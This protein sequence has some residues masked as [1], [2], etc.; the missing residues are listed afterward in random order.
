[1]KSIFFPY[2]L[3]PSLTL[4]NRIVMAPMT[5]RKAGVDYSPTEQRI[6]YYARRS[7]AG[8][9]ITEGTLISADAI[10]YGNV[11]GIFRESHIEGWKRVTD[12]VHQN[13]GCIF[14][15]LW[16]CGRI[17]HHSFHEGRA[18]IS[19][20][21]TLANVKLGSTN[22]LCSQAKEATRLDITNLISDF[23]Y[24]AHNAIRAGF[25]GVEIHAANGY[26]LDQFLHYSTNHRKDE[27]G[28]TPE[29]I[30][31]FPLEVVHAC[32]Q[33][34]GYEKVGIRLS[35]AGHM[36]EIQANDSDKSIFAYFLNALKSLGIAYVHTGN[37]DDSKQYPELN[38]M[39]MTEFLRMHY[40]GNL[41]ASGGY[42]FENA[43]RF[44]SENKFDLIALGRP[45]I[46]NDNLIE[47]L[48]N[49]K[50]LKTYHPDMLQILY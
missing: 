36:N 42:S 2:P 47:L 12:A 31:R 1:M 17:S 6:E 5:R 19:A 35:P 37:F 29:N 15:Q 3:S 33:E 34:I 32:G 18:P 16:H 28:L 25:D 27:Y 9:I 11:P 41:I 46:A 14:M 7:G 38:D 44:I 4:K 13:G 39:S 23:A 24:A 43:E 30:S 26:L 50:L 40:D 21:S 8:L 49:R 20:S 10:G 22:L 45:F 48:Q